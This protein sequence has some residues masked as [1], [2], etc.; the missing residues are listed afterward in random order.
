MINVNKRL[1]LLATQVGSSLMLNIPKHQVISTFF[2]SD[3]NA[4]ME[5]ILS[6]TCEC[7]MSNIICDLYLAVLILSDALQA[8]EYR[9]N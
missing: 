7:T 3:L 4:A 8:Q 5:Y 2:N 1:S 6:N 9:K